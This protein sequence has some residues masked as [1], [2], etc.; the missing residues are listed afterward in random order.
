MKI[1]LLS[2][3]H[4]RLDAMQAGMKVL[5]HAGAEMFI[6]CGDVGGEKIL[7]CL[8]G[9]NAIVV[10]G[11]CDFDRAGLARYAAQI[12]INCQGEFAEL[13]IAGKKIV[14]THGDDGKLMRKLLAGNRHDYLLHGH[15]HLAT[16][17]RLGRLRIINPGAL[18]RASVKT[19]AILNPAEDQLERLV[20]QV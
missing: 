8:A 20:V 2:D 18:Y 9:E 5:K 4:D 10:W 17:D 12:G 1:G 13:E 3:T 16:D 14:I 7:D 15:T 6:H 11:N 19:V